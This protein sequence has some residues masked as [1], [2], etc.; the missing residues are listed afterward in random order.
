M[1]A[2]GFPWKCTGGLRIASCDGLGDFIVRVF[3]LFDKLYAAKIQI[4]ATSFCAFGYK[5][6]NL[7]HLANL[8]SDDDKNL[9]QTILFDLTFHIN[10]P[11]WTERTINV[12]FTV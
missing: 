7:I 4:L 1:L 12:Q 10:L 3:M 8:N 6:E 5:Q 11:V 9:F 2:C